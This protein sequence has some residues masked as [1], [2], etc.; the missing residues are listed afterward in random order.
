MK[1][2]YD[3][4]KAGAHNAFIDPEGYK[5]YIADREQAFETEF[6]RQLSGGH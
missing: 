5:R 1:A 4:W 2:K 3:R 6:Q